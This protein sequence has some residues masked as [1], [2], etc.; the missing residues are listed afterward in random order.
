MRSG[1]INLYLSGME[2]VDIQAQ[3]RHRSLTQ[4]MEYLRELDLFCKKD[5]LDKEKGF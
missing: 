3:C 2:L 1:A 4:A 5:H